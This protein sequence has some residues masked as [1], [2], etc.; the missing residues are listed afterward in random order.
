MSV[1]ELLN[2][3]LAEIPKMRS[4]E[5]FLVKDLFRGYEWARISKEDREALGEAFSAK[6]D[7]ELDAVVMKWDRTSSNQQKYR[8]R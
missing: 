4:N 6:V 3:M 7:A 1:E 8:I 5:S 2:Q